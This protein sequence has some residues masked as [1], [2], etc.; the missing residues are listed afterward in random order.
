MRIMPNSTGLNGMV[1]YIS[2]R[3]L[4]LLFRTTTSKPVSSLER[5]NFGSENRRKV[6]FL[7]LTILL[8]WNTAV[9]E[10]AMLSTLIRDFNSRREL[11]WGPLVSG[12]CFPRDGI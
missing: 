11:R 1:R 12:Q 8:G 3:V 4:V 5:E 7:W 6:R 2:M 10:H 9:L